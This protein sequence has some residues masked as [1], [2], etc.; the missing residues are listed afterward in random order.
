MEEIKQSIIK[1]AEERLKCTYTPDIRIRILIDMKEEL[2][3]LKQANSVF[4]ENN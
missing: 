4:S 3:A 1:R 2:E